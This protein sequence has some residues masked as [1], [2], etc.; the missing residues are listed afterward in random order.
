MSTVKSTAPASGGLSRRRMPLG[1]LVI[2]LGLGVM[3][4]SSVNIV[5]YELRV[6]A[7]RV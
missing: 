2:G 6:A 3:L 7:E 4:T 5:Q 1:L